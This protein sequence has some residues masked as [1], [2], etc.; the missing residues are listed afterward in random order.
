MKIRH[1]IILTA[2]IVC[3]TFVFMLSGCKKNVFSPKTTINQSEDTTNI[4][5]NSDNSNINSDSDTDSDIGTDPNNKS[6][7]F[8]SDTGTKLNMQIEWSLSGKTNGEYTL[9][10]NVYIISNSIYVSSRTN[11]IILIGKAEKLFTTDTIDIDE[12]DEVTKTLIA[13]NSVQYTEATLPESVDISAK[14]MF[15]GTYSGIM[16][17]CLSAQSTV[18]LKNKSK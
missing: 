15:N 4:G 9:T 5:L 12:S 6:G 16:I 7:S 18:M 1:I 11:G 2:F 8:K 10:A 3:L 14:W 13:T 17:E